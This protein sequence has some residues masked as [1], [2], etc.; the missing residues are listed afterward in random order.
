MRSLLD[1]NVLISLLD[2]DHPFHVRAHQ[3][4]SIN[5]AFG[6]ASCPITENGVIRIMSNHGY[7]Q[8][9]RLNSFQLISGLQ[10]FIAQ[11][12]H[13]FWPDDISFRN[14][15]IFKSERIHSAGQ[16]TD[17]YLLALAT[18]K[19]GQ[20]ATFDTNISL[21]ALTKAKKD[22]LCVI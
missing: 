16:L 1:I 5:S 21:S 15:D 4:W 8:N 9:N 19:G 10:S 14:G 7:R 12:D 11:T 3:W 6:W 18:E 17:L 22:N 2:P 20:L 13:V